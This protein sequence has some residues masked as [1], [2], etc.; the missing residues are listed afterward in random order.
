MR[1][2]VESL[3]SILRPITPIVLLVAI[4]CTAAIV[5]AQEAPVWRAGA[6]AIDITPEGRVWMAGYAFRNKPSE[7]IAQRLNAKALA[8]DH[9]AS[10][11]IVIVTLDL[12]G[13]PRELRGRIEQEVREKFELPP[14]SLLLN[15]SH[16]HSGPALSSRRVDDPTYAEKAD[17]YQQELGNKI[18]QVIGEALSRRE[19]ADLYFTEARAGFAMNRRLRVGSEIRNSPNPKGP[20][21]HD[22]PVLRVL[23]SE[24]ELRAILFGYACHNTTANFYTING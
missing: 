23:G 4:A 10:G 15:A 16:T 1:P 8:I 7:G 24:G 19:P 3:R 5:N 13:V 9:S 6:A 21:D 22:V 2:I 17:T 14:E 20:V 12:I 18:V 11:R